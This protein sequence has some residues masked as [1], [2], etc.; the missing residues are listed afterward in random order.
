M[1]RR[2]AQKL[3]PRIEAGGYVPDGLR[4]GQVAQFAGQVIR[5][6]QAGA[7]AQQAVVVVDEPHEAAVDALVI[8]HVRVGG[9]DAG[10]FADDLRQRALGANQIVVNLAGARLIAVE[11][12]LLQPVVQV[13]DCC[14]AHGILLQG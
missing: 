3:V 2:L 4:H 6:R 1:P 9:V 8:R 5:Q 12:G 11:N 7:A 13:G 10:G 14:A